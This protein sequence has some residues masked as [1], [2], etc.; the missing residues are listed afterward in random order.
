[1]VTEV[2]GSPSF[3]REGAEL[4]ENLLFSTETSA[5]LRVVEGASEILPG[6]LLGAPDSIPHT[7]SVKEYPTGII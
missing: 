6:P 3:S 4:C 5:F 2:Q 1:M 7:Q